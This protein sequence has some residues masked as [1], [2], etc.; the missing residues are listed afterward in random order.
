MRPVAVC[1]HIVIFATNLFHEQLC[2]ICPIRRSNDRF[3]YIGRE[4]NC[5]PLRNLLPP[6]RVVQVLNVRTMTSDCKWPLG[7][8]TKLGLARHP[9]CDS[10]FGSA[11]LFTTLVL[12][13]CVD[14]C[15]ILAIWFLHSIHVRSMLA[16]V[17]SQLCEE[18]WLTLEWTGS[19][20][21]W[22]AAVGITGSLYN[23]GVVGEWGKT[24]PVEKTQPVW[25]SFSPA[26]YRGN[27]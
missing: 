26:V 19:W 20:H 5:L 14:S 24:L 6:P 21:E 15:W 7:G 3:L 17:E 25:A 11:A 16:R 1:S 2:F 12:R 22:T 23:K 18:P 8:W 10:K 4:E 27:G 9:Q 13:A